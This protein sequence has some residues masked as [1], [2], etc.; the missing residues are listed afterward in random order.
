MSEH[1][2]YHKDVMV[3]AR[4]GSIVYPNPLNSED[5]PAEYQVAPLDHS[6]YPDGA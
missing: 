5:T 1:I 2:T 6:V 3:T 4:N